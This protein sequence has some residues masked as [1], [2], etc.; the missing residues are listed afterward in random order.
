MIKFVWRNASK[1][2]DS[3][4]SAIFDVKPGSKLLI[5]GFGVCGVPENLIRAIHRKKIC[6]LNIYTNLSG[7]N[8]YGPGL[9]VG[10]KL[11]NSFH[12]S[13]IGAN[14]ELERQ[15]LNGEIELDLI[16]QGSLIERFRAGRQGLYGFY[17]PTGVGTLVENGGFP[18]KYFLGGKTVEKYSEPRPFLIDFGKKY[19][20][21]KGIYGDLAIIKA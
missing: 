1:V 3:A 9:L 17:T 2:F 18:M 10:A 15:Y 12:A 5:G 11:V 13:Y 6:N 21:E 8:T 7:T 16:P 4:E 14:E 20:L 19:L